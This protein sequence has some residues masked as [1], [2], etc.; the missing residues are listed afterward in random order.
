M[1]WSESKKRGIWTHT[2]A[3]WKKRAVA[4]D[5]E[6]G[7]QGKPGGRQAEVTAKITLGSG[8]VSCRPLELL[9]SLPTALPANLD[10]HH[11]GRVGVDTR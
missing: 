8:S 2:V 10:L 9:N 11:H 5:V 3:A 4:A 6:W 1:H 7:T